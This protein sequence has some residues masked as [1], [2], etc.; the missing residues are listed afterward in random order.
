MPFHEREDK[1]LNILLQNE[2]VTVDELAGKLF[3]SKPILRGDLIK[4]E[5][6]GII[7]RT[8]GGATL[9]KNSADTK[10]PFTLRE[11]EQNSA[12]VS[13]AKK[14]VTFIKDGDIIMLDATTTAYNLVPYL[15]EFKNIIVITSSAKISFVLGEMGINNICTGGHMINKSFSYVG[16]D[17]QNTVANYNADIM[18]FSCRALSDDGRLSDNSIEE[19]QLRKAMMKH[20]KKK[21]FLCD[22]S[23]IGKVCLN[24]LCH[25]S[26]VDEIICEKELPEEIAKMCK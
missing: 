1:I 17:A 2:S 25:V 5:K 9:I 13:I 18:F 11:Q 24:N 16:S 14:A 15:T 22:S 7:I 10:I 8:H 20:S 6:K 19:N 26:D 23:K 4:L 21:I 3:I 12:K